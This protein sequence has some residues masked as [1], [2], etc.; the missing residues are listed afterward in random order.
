M[1]EMG[2]FLNSILSF[3]SK[4]YSKSLIRVGVHPYWMKKL[5]DTFNSTVVWLLI[6]ARVRRIV[7][8]V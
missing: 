3:C 7:I 8:K 6:V 2:S 1:K 4:L 5:D